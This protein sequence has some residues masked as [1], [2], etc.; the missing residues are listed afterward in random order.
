[1]ETLIFPAINLAALLGILAFYLRKPLADFVSSRHVTVR[2]EIQASHDA[3]ADAK[4]RSAEISARLVGMGAELNSLREQARQDGE[5]SKDEI[6]GAAR[7]LSLMIVSDAKAS[8]SAMQTEFREALGRDL[9]AMALARAEVRLRDR[10][11]GEDH[12]R[13]RQEFSTLV[14]KTQ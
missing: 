12:A 5:K 4:A 11:T 7:R 6:L 10:L 13:I 8:T 2:S 3:L 1:M 14:E 9:T